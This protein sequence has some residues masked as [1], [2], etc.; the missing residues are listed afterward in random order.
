MSDVKDVTDENFSSVILESK[1]PFLVQV[2][3]DWSG[4]CFLMAKIIDQLAHEFQPQV[5]FA[6]VNIDLNQKLTE[7][8]GITELPFLLFFKDGKLVH[9]LIGLQSKNFLKSQI[10]G[11]LLPDH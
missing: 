5:K 1:D 3:A 9:H 2:Q 11:F 4:E 6:C 8:Y 10:I 7:D